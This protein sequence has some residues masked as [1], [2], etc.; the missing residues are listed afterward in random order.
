MK[1]KKKEEE[2]KEKNTKEAGPQ[3]WKHKK[4]TLIWL[5]LYLNQVL[6]SFAQTYAASPEQCDCLPVSTHQQP[7]SIYN[8]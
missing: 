7:Y 4:N 5:Y 6:S 8:V 2:R 1:L 3:R